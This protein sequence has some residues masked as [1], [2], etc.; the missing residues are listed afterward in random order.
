MLTPI[1]PISGL[2]FPRRL[3]SGL[4]WNCSFHGGWDRTIQRVESRRVCWYSLQLMHQFPIHSLSRQ[5]S[6]TPLNCGET[7]LSK[8]DPCMSQQ[9]LSDCSLGKARGICLCIGK[10]VEGVSAK[11]LQFL[12]PE[13]ICAQC[14]RSSPGHHGPNSVLL[15]LWS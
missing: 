15:M 1:N 8:L 3:A 5:S 9:K 14:E 13:P 11:P 6:S 12:H 7:L 2:S 4:S 10:R